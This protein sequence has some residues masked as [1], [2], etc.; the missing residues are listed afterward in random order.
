MNEIKPIR[1]ITLSE[2]IMREDDEYRRVYL[3]PLRAKW[4]AEVN[5]MWLDF[6]RDGELIIAKPKDGK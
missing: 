5:R 4:Q 2:Q 3:E 6:C 1:P